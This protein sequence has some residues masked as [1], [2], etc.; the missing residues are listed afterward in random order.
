MRLVETDDAPR[1]AG[2]YS[3]AVVARG[4]VFV[5]GL[6][7]IIPGTNR[8]IPDGI[9]AQAEQVLANLRAVLRAAGSDL[10][11]V[12]SV[13]IFIPD[14]AVWGAVNEVYA[15]VMGGHRPARTVIPCGSLHY[16]AL[17]EVNAVAEGSDASG[18]EQAATL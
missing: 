16:G 13:Q 11:R 14:I 8:Q 3:Q 15:R 5:A 4:L 6:L 10:D 9:T 12:V 1:P 7:P 2:H 18:G 17:L